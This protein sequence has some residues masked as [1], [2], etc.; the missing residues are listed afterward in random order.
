MND[1]MSELSKNYPGTGDIRLR[2]EMTNAN[3]VSGK[4]PFQLFHQILT[5]EG[6][7]VSIDWGDGS[8]ETLTGKTAYSPEHTY[9]KTGEYTVKLTGSKFIGV[10]GFPTFDSTFQCTVREIL[11]LK[12]P[13]DSKS[14]SLRYTFNGCIRL[15]GNIPEWDDCI[16]NTY[17]TYR[18]C[19]SLTGNIPA[20]GA[21]I[22]DATYTYFNCARLTG[23][24]PEW[25]PNIINATG[26]YWGCTSLTGNIPAWG[27]NITSAETTY[28]GCSGLTGSIPLWGINIKSAYGTYKGCTGLTGKIPKWGTNI[29]SAT[30]TYWGCI[31]LTGNIPK[32]GPKIV[33]AGFTYSRCTGLTGKIPKWGTNILD[34]GYTYHNCS[35]LDCCS[36]KLLQDLMP[37]RIRFHENCVYGCARAV[38]Q[39]FAEDWGGSQVSC[40]I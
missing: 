19:A 34:V 8:V 26:T 18:A 17:G 27:T 16:V 40:S 33:Y 25:G 28:E 14:V 29:T 12:M 9:A 5:E 36:E 22:V 1:V 30:S 31:G 4:Y 24:V 21:N 2:I 37:S 13:T 6:G 3:R 20:W 39:C 10:N 23:N 32:W 38:R 11:S 15:T 7:S 35:G